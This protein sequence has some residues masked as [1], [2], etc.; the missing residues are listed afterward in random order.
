[1]VERAAA[2]LR[3]DRAERRRRSRELSPK[4]LRHA[5]RARTAT[6]SRTSTSPAAGSRRSRTCATTGG[7]RSWR[8]RSAAT[9]GSRGIYGTGTVHVAR[10]ARSSTSSR[11]AFPELPGPAGDHRRRGRPGHDVVRLRGAAHG[12][13]RRP[14]P[15]ARLGEGEGRRRARR[16]PARRRTRR[17]STA[18]P[19]S[20]HDATP[21]AHRSGSRGAHGAS[22]ASTCCCCRSGPTCRTS[23]ATRRCRSSGSRCWCC[24]ATATRSSSCRASKRRGSTPQPELFE[25]V[26]VGR[27]RRPDRARRRA[28]RRSARAGRDRRPHL[29][30]LRARPPARAPGGRRS[31]RASEVVGPIRMVKDADEIAAL[32][33]G[34]ARGRRDRGEMRALAVRRPHR[35][36][37]APRARRAHAR[38]GPRAG[39]LRDRRRRRA[40]PRA[41]TTSRQPTGAIARRRRRAVRLRRHDAAATAPTSRGCST[42]ASRPTEVRDVYAVLVEAQEAG[43]RAATVGTPCEDVDAAAR[44]VIAAAGFGEHFVHRVGH[45][46]GTEAHEDPYMVAGN[47]LPLAA[48][49]RVQRRAR[50][51]LPG[52]VRH[53]ARRHRRR[54]RRPVRAASTTRRAI[55]RSSADRSHAMKLDV[56]TFLLQWATGGLLFCWVTTRRREV[57]LGYGWLLRS[58]FGVMAVGA[59]ALFLDAATSPTRASV[60]LAASIG[61]VLRRRGRA[62]RC[63]SCDGA[64]A[65]AA[66]RRCAP[67]GSAR[68]AAMIGREA[69]D[70]AGRASAVPEFPPVLDLVAPVTRRRRSARGRGVRGRPV[71]ARR[72]PAR[73]SAQRSSAR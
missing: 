18:C 26:T 61:V 8:A 71:R 14:R 42:S 2:V 70:D 54:D 9:R 6:A 29:G 49:P 35:A 46:I 16:V 66:A 41:R 33:R 50:H 53:A 56:A 48:G 19:G 39:E 11:R 28:G 64:R 62:R 24:R 17:A 15:A 36:R 38:A 63:P 25:I 58:V 67:T 32:Q 55:S 69:S 65:C 1:M 5:A 12:P 68:V 3:R 40:T 27:D 59:A 72:G 4:G 37:R 20:T 7:S 51:L 45:G 22:S 34:R 13:R 43:V 10:L 52:P 44:R 30:A 31:S 60:A 47:D 57:S 23:P 73:S 21:I